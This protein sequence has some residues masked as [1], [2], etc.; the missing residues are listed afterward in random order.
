MR[1]LSL[2][3]VLLL[4]AIPASASQLC[5]NQL[6]DMVVV[7]TY[8]YFQNPDGSITWVPMGSDITYYWI[9]VCVDTTPSGGTPPPPPPNQPM[10]PY[11]PVVAI[12][13]IDSTDPYR[14]SLAADVQ[15]KDPY[16][17]PVKVEF[18]ANGLRRGSI[19]FDRDGRFI[20][21]VPP[22]WGF[23]DGTSPLVVKACNAN[24]TCGEG[25]TEIVRGRLSPLHRSE[26]IRTRHIEG[27]E[28]K[29]NEFGHTFQ[30][31]YVNTTFN[32]PEWGWNSR[33]QLTDSVVTIAGFTGSYPPEFRPR[34]TTTGTV[35][36]GSQIATWCNV[37]PYGC[38]ACDSRCA[39]PSTFGYGP[40]VVDK[41][42]EFWVVEP[43]LIPTVIWSGGTLQVGWYY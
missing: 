28:Y 43:F 26:K 8:G 41:L 5:W 12:N 13:H 40:T 7:T 29:L 27:D 32:A 2:A 33:I 42:E 34:I 14:V 21:D 20:F 25:R 15:T 6:E 9:F 31:G 38:T 3:I 24:G 30:Q 10:V 22:L 1:R 39:N 19:P 37:R 36:N 4:A 16:N 17:P 35:W 18:Y 11:L 23:P